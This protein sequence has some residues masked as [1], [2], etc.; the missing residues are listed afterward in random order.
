M[1][2]RDPKKLLTSASL[3]LAVLL[4]TA[5]Q[6]RAQF[7]FGTPENL[8]PVVNSAFGEAYAT[9]SADGLTIFF[10][11]DRPGGEG[12]G[13]IWTTMRNGPSDPWQPPVNLGP[14]VNTAYGDWVP[15]IS[16]DGLTLFLQSNRP[17]GLGDSDI[18]MATRNGPSDPWEAPVNLGPVVNTSSWDG[19]AR[20]TADELTLAFQSNRPGGFGGLDLWITTR[21]TP[22]DA[23]GSPVNLGPTVNSSSIDGAPEFTADGLTLFFGSTRPGGFGW[24]DNWLTTRA[25]VSDPWEPPVNLGPLVNTSYADNG[26]AITADSRTLIFTSDRPG[27]SG[28]LDLWQVAVIPNC[29]AD[30]NGDG[31]VGPVDLATLLGNWGPCDD[32]PMDFNDDGVIGPFDLATLLGS[33]GP[34]PCNEC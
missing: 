8:G 27:G 18:W 23:W 26:P 5:G 14:P 10:Q 12:G 21:A 9:V 17:G 3:V 4:A 29:P 24:V 34:C 25:S 30:L 16:K 1:C 20:I 15:G 28:E 11:S 32:C 13:D 31:T 2:T 19:Y 7:T 22:S 6:L 33:W